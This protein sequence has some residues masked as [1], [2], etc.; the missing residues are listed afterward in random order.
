MVE[1]NDSESNSKSSGLLVNRQSVRHKHT[2]DD[3][4][5]L[6]N[7]ISLADSAIRHTATGKLSLILEQIQFLQAQ[8]QK[9]LDETSLSQRLSSAACNFRKRAG[10]IYHL[11]RRDSG[12]FYIS[13]LSPEEWGLGLPHH[14]QG[15]YRLEAD[16]S[17]TPVNRL[18]EVTKKN[19]WA[20]RLMA[21]T[22]E[23]STKSSFLAIE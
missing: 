13:M 8:A 18:D 21:A 10:T 6:A 20:E 12:Q 3:I 2:A 9:I 22:D 4:V 15:S 17:W 19:A 16:S 5:R 1:R 7:E 23:A 11:Y 14:F